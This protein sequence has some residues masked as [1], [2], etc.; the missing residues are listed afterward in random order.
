MTA[1]QVAAT[2]GISARKVYDLAAPA[3]LGAGLAKKL[4]NISGIS[5]PSVSR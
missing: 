3:A 1:D 2:L 4:P 5:F